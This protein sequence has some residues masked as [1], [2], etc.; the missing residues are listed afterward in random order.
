MSVR[1]NQLGGIVQNENFTH[2][3]VGGLNRCEKF[4]IAVASGRFALHPAYITKCERE[5]RFVAE[6]E[7]EWGNPKFLPELL[8]KVKANDY[9]FKAP[10][11]WR[12]WLI[13]HADQYPRGAFTGMKFI[14]ASSKAKSRTIVSII[15]A[16]GGKHVPVDAL[17]SRLD[18]EF[19]NKEQ[20]NYC[21]TEH[22][23]ISR[24]NSDFL[25]KRKVEVLNINFINQH[26]IQSTQ[27]PSLKQFVSS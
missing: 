17:N 25:T 1:I 7:Y 3:I 23:F 9:L 26:L 14:V 11:K 10:Y 13:K 20:V 6:D 19:L 21:L 2:L 8:G 5:G 15:E 24:E 22:N 16:G 27:L 18:A 12:Q 4:L